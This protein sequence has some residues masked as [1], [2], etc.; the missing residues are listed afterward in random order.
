MPANNGSS[1]PLPRPHP[2]RAVTMSVCLPEPG[3]G[4]VLGHTHISEARG[5]RAGVLG[6]VA[7]AILGTKEACFFLF[8]HPAKAEGWGSGEL[9]GPSFPTGSGCHGFK[10]WLSW[11]LTCAEQPISAELR[12]QLTSWMEA[13]GWA[14]TAGPYRWGPGG[15]EGGLRRRLPQ[16]SPAP[17]I[18]ATCL[19]FPTRLRGDATLG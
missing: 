10:R 18:L 12:L 3:T 14:G 1:D 19:L 8:H 16:S 2:A 5:G 6:G 15:K 7:G 11:R 4:R 13:S 9:R 17:Q